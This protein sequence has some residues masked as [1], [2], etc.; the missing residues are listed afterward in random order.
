MK[1]KRVLAALLA[2]TLLV[3]ASGCRK[4]NTSGGNESDEYYW[5]TIEYGSDWTD[6]AGEGTQSGGTTSGGSSGGSTS[7]SKNNSSS[8]KGGTSSSTA[9]EDTLATGNAKQKKINL[10]GKSYVNEREAYE[11]KNPPYKVPNNLK[12][13]TVKFATWIDHTTTEA[14]YPMANFEKATGIKVEWTQIPQKDYYSKLVTMVASDT[15]PD[16]ILENNS[17][18][19][20]IFEVCQ[21]LNKIKS[22]DMNDPIW[23]KGYFNYSK[24]NGNIY[25][26]NVRNSVWQTGYLLFYNKKVLTE[27]GITTPDDY[28]KAGKWNWSNL[29]KMLTEFTA[30][31]K[32]YTG[33]AMDTIQYAGAS[34]TGF[35]M[36][37]GDK[38]VTGIHSSEFTAACQAL[39]DIK[40][41]KLFGGSAASIM[42]GTSA[43]LVTDSYGLKK[44]GYF[45]GVASNVLGFA[46]V[47][48]PTGG[49]QYYPSHYRAYA[50]CKGAKNPEGAGY[51]LRYFLDPYNYNWDDIFLSKDAQKA[52]LNYC[53]DVSFDKKVFDYAICRPAFIGD[54][55]ENYWESQ[56]YWDTTINRGVASQLST[57]INTISGEIEKSAVPKANDILSKLS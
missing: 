42:K 17:S 9:V 53:S 24:V 27:N 13:T 29:V 34:G 43:A 5:S 50:V 4:S 39:Y 15:A 31:N 1:Q 55:K 54:D 19:P 11:A 56:H 36:K 26:C 12:G 40:D 45:K 32:S 30:L 37:S 49:E 23:D 22:I 28:I 25:H 20:M 7:S 14:K 33:L 38:F 48:N 47:P 18:M 44:T 41:K 51:F 46:P 8:N 6:T 2:V 21:P 10:F 57:Y 16:V 52:Y 3:S 35:L